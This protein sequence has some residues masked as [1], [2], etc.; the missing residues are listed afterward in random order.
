[1]D[2]SVFNKLMDVAVGDGE[3][4]LVIRNARVVNMFMHDVEVADVIVT[5]GRIA[6]VVDAGTAQSGSGTTVIDADGTYA[7]PGLFDA[8]FHMGGSHLPVVGLAEALL[9]RGTTAIATDFYEIYTVA[10]PEGVREALAAVEPTGLKAKF[11]APL[12]LLGLESVGTFGWDVNADDFVEMLKWPET[13]GVMEPPASIVLARQPEVLRVIE[14][15]TALGKTF[16]GHAPGLVDRSLQAYLSVGASSDHESQTEGEAVAK[17]RRGMQPMMRQGS[18]APDLPNL[19]SMAL[20]HPQST[21]WMMVCSDEVDPGDLVRNGHMDEKVRMVTQAGV[22]PITALAMASTNVAEYFNLGADLGT[23][24]PG[25][26]ADIV[27]VDDLDDYRPD[28]VVADGKLVA[29]DGKPIEPTTAF[30]VPE[31]LLSRVNL[32]HQLTAADFEFTV[33]SEAKSARVRTIGVDDGSLISNALERELN[34]SGGVIQPD[35]SSDVLNIAIVERHRGSGTIAQ[36]FA[37]GFG[38][39]DGAVAMTYCHVYHNILVVGASSEDMALAANSIA[40]LGG[41]IVVVRNGEIIASWRLPIV[42][43]IGDQPLGDAQPAFDAVNE[44][45]TELGCKLTSPVLS[46]SFV[47][48]PTI[49]ALGLTDRGLY[50]VNSGEFLEPVIELVN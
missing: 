1:M 16:A 35:I 36:S 44:A 22:D 4:D 11:L 14:H 6:A 37:S 40:E 19:V 25:R 2:V 46:L 28:V 32:P 5:E 8:H 17:L 27:L 20:N 3:P 7:T 48:L 18:A 38:F 47:A 9:A 29:R 24:A 10:G 49:P 41:G 15:M 42:G 12:H 33:G 21:R 45:I 13:V 30:E 26:R 50:D 23:I 31:R 34:V 43:V 39:N